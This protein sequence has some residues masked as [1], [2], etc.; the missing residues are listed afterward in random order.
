[1]PQLSVA[2]STKY[3]GQA[4]LN[5]GHARVTS[6]RKFLEKYTSPL[7]FSS[8]RII[9]LGCAGG[10]LLEQ[11]TGNGNVLECFEA[12]VNYH[13]VFHE[14]MSKANH[15]SYVLHTRLFDENAITPLSVD[16]FLSSHVIEHIPDPCATLRLMYGALKPGAVMFHEMPRKTLE[17]VLQV[18]GGLFHTTF[19]TVETVRNVFTAV[20]FE[21][22]AIETF[23]NFQEVDPSGRGKYIRSLFR[24]PLSADVYTA[25]DER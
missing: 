7:K 21:E 23:K 1:M 10:F 25:V 12:S 14:T 15:S 18:Q 17:G 2:Y 9:E 16:V 3:H 8:L 20:G 6:Q 24:K 13:S 4:K 5:I 11:F 19:W 22:I